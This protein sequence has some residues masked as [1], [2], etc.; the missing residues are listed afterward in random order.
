MLQKSTITYK[1]NRDEALNIMLDVKN[2]YEAVKA[3]YASKAA[4]VPSKKS[5]ADAKIAEI[6]GII[7]TRI[8]PK[9][10]NLLSLATEADTR[11]KTLEDIENQVNSGKTLN[12]VNVPTQ[13]YSQ[14]VQDGGL[15]NAKD[16]VD[17]KEDL[18]QVRIDST[19][20]K[21]DAL[22]K[23]QECQLFN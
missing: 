14:M 13:L 22:R 19:E 4:A 18:E 7:N 17:S 21:Q 3:C 12:D 10:L 5:E 8:A 11:L 15:T 23:S 9:T 6:D 2:S 1:N 20:L 16:I